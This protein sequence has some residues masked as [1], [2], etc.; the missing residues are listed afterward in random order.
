MAP[1]FIIFSG[2]TPKKAG[3]QITISASL[4]SCNDPTLLEIP[5]AIAGLIVYLAIYLLHLK[6]SFPLL[7]SGKLPLW[8]FIFAAVCHVRIITSPTLPMA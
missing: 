2:F 4:F 3:S 7:S 5:W 8:I 1:P 6:L